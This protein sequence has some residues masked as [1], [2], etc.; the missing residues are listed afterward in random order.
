MR[1]RRSYSPSTWVDSVTTI[2]VLPHLP[3]GPVDILACIGKDSAFYGYAS[4]TS[5]PL[6]KQSFALRMVCKGK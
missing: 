2:S 5:Y 6:D 1:G 4:I 3:E